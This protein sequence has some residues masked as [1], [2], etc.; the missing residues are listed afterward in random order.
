MAT[1]NESQK[2]TLR[3]HNP[4]LTHD[5]ELSADLT[6]KFIHH[7]LFNE[8]MIDEIKAERTR[9]D[10][11]QKLLLQLPR[12]G[13]RAFD[14]FVHSIQDTYPWL[15][16]ELRKTHH[17][18]SL[19]TEPEMISLKEKV[20]IY[21]HEHFG[22]S[23][24][25]CEEDKKDI[26][27]FLYKHLKSHAEDPVDNMNAR[28]DS[29][30]SDISED[31]QALQELNQNQSQVNEKD[32]ENRVL[33]KVF[34]ILTGDK[35]DETQNSPEDLDC[36]DGP[37]HITLETIE[38]KVNQMNKQ[39]ENLQNEIKDCFSVLGLEN[40]KYSLPEVLE[41]YKE[42][43]QSE[44]AELSKMRDRL[45]T[46]E[47][48]RHKLEEKLKAKE[49]EL[50]NS[51]N[52]LANAEHA[53]EKSKVLM[54]D[55]K[56]KCEKLEQIQV[57]HLE[58]QQTLMTLKSMVQ[59][60]GPVQR[61]SRDTFRYQG[62]YDEVDGNSLQLPKLTQSRSSRAVKQSRKSAYK[63]RSSSNH[64]ELPQPQNHSSGYWKY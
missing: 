14:M 55:L 38:K 34:S 11:V 17:K 31:I 7:G 62:A 47:R 56:A 23:R 13:P 20:D 40:C 41:T 12:R 35:S 54:R 52:D 37:C 50:Q 43:R 51:I 18:I 30:Q 49:R 25:L 64:H 15:A 16:E 26:R 5:L 9:R 4:D 57:K 48:Q 2:R 28:R 1:M 29:I 39:V 10:R 8:D 59:E 61:Q 36:V 6:A 53:N 27:K 58:K 19:K 24:R 3:I 44:V 46:L 60:L 22:R 32:I 42:K 45:D 21:V 33:Q 63:D